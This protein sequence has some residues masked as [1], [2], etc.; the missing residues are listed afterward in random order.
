LVVA[1]SI[2]V[3]C[4]LHVLQEHGEHLNHG[5]LRGEA[6]PCFHA[7]VLELSQLE[8]KNPPGLGHSIGFGTQLEILAVRPTDV[9]SAFEIRLRFT[10]I[11]HPPIVKKHEMVQ[12][13]EV[14]A[15]T[16]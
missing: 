11:A 13:G 7:V 15:A 10:G 14:G 12:T 16:D 8:L 2:I 5:K 4:R 9:P 1:K 6:T 3:L